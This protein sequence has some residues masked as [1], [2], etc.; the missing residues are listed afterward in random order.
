M[1][2]MF[3][4][5]DGKLPTYAWPGGYPVIY[6]CNDG[7]V[8]CPACANNENGSQAYTGPFDPGLGRDWHIVAQDIHYEGAPEQCVHCGEEIESAYGDPEKED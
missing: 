8:M 3:R 7:A 6:I 2:N 1:S 5:D 4:D